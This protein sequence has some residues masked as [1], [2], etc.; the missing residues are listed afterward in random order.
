MADWATIS[1]LATAG[2]TLVLAVATFASVRSGS[3]SARVAERS[4]LA[5]LRP[6]LMPSQQQDPEQKILFVD[7]HWVKVPGGAATAEA[8]DGAVYMTMSL[9]N[10]G[11]GM[12]V[13]HG[14]VFHPERVLDNTH[15]SPG[16]FHRLTRDIYI[17][18]NGLGFWQGVF[19][20]PEV[21]EFTV[22][23]TAIA[24]RNV[25]GIDLLY[26][27]HEGGQRTIT[28]FALIPRTDGGWLCTVGRHWNL[29]RRD[30]R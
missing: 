5:G 22:A 3:R 21:A 26:G 25:L 4:L 9:R 2:G 8:N 16:D 11:S 23:A 13:L 10:A 20:E 14:W 15:P 7:S 28:R 30:P 24:A 18:P 1:S 29:D 17:P 19:R 27:D 12:A 6:V